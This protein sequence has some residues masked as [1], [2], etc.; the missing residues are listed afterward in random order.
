MWIWRRME[1][2]NWTEHIEEELARIEE[3]RTLIYRI[4]KSQRKWIGQ[5]LRGDSLLKTVIEGN[6]G[7]KENKRKSGRPRQLEGSKGDGLWV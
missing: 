7:E 2:I 5:M 1:N 6:N 3:E 4:R